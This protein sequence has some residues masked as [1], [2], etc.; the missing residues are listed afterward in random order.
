MTKAS[1]T[2]PAWPVHTRHRSVAQ[3]CFGAVA[4]EGNACTQGRNPIGCL[5][6]P[7]VG[8]AASLAAKTKPRRLPVA[9]SG[10]FLFLEIVGIASGKHPNAH[11]LHACEP[12]AHFMKN[13][14]YRT[15]G[16]VPKTFHEPFASQAACQ[17]SQRQHRLSPEGPRAEGATCCK[18]LTAHIDQETSTAEPLIPIWLRKAGFANAYQHPF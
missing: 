2:Q 8:A 6:S 16:N 7:R 10:K 15:L 14:C 5:S 13:D 1:T 4:T 17:I 11:F 9:W 3:R 18:C 12:W